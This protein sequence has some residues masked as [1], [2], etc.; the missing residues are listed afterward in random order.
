MKRKLIK[1]TALGLAINMLASTIAPTVAYALTA[2]PS[3]PEFSS[4]E[5]VATTDM[6]SVFSGDFNYNLPV[7]EIPG[8]DGAGYALS[9]AYHAGNSSEEEAS[10]VGYGFTLNPGS[11]NRSTRGFPDDYHNTAIEKYNKSPLNLTASGGANLGL[12]VF[13]T[14]LGLSASKTLRYNN[15]QGVANTFGFGFRIKGIG[16]LNVSTGPQGTT[17]SAGVDIMGIVRKHMGPSKESNSNSFKDVF[18]KMLTKSIQR[19]DVN[20][21]V[22]G[23]FVPS[24][25]VRTTAMS[26]FETKSF[27]FTAS[28]SVNP[29]PVPVGIDAGISGNV[30]V[31]RNEEKASYNAYGYQHNQPS[32]HFSGDNKPTLSDYYIEK[33]SPYKKRE[34]FTG[35]PFNN[36]DNFVAA[37]EGISGGFRYF[38]E[39]AGHFYPD[40]KRNATTLGSFGLTGEVLTAWGFDVQLGLGENVGQVKNWESQGASKD[41]QF[42]K[43]GTFRFAN[44]MG[45]K[46]SYGTSSISVAKIDAVSVVDGPRSIS[47]LNPDGILPKPTSSSYIGVHTAEDVLT[48][49]KKYNNTISSLIANSN[50]QNK[51]GIVE[52]A[53]T[54][55]DGMNYVYGQPVF[56]KNDVNMQF[57]VDHNAS[58]L[59]DYDYIAYKPQSEPVG[60]GSNTNIIDLSKH[61]TAVGE[62]RKVPYTNNY[63]LT[64]ITTPDYVDVNGNG[65][66]NNDFG[67]WTSMHYYNKYGANAPDTGNKWY[68]WRTPYTGLLY[69]KGQIS[70]TTD[71]VGSVSCGEK[72]VQYLKAVETKTHI[73]FFITNKSTFARFSAFIP[74]DVLASFPDIAQRDAY[75]SKYFE[76]SGVARKDGFDAKALDGTSDPASVRR[77]DSR[78]TNELEYLEKVVLFS[79]T[80]LT[81]PLKT[82]RFAYDYSLVQNLP[83]NVEGRYPSGKTSTQSGKLTLK[84]VWFEYEDVIGAKISPYEF[85]YQYKPVIEIPVEIQARYPHIFGAGNY[86]GGKFSNDAQNPDYSPHL[87]DGWGNIQQYAKERQKYM[88]PWAYQGNEPNPYITGTHP[89]N[90]I[91]NNR[92]VDIG[93][94]SDVTPVTANIVKVDPAAWQLKRI[95]LPSG[96]EILIEYEQK[97]YASVQDKAPMA[98]ASLVD[99]DEKNG[100]DLPIYY[101]NGN[102]LGL[103]TPQDYDETVALM[104]KEFQEKIPT[105]PTERVKFDKKIYFKFLYNLKPNDATVPSLDQCT[106]EYISGYSGIYSIIADAVNER[107]KIT[108]TGEKA[109]DRLGVP[110][111]ASHDFYMTQRRGKLDGSFGCVGNLSLEVEPKAKDFFNGNGFAQVG[112]FVSIIKTMIGANLTSFWKKV[113]IEEVGQKLNK[114]LSYLRIPMIKAKKGGGV[115]VKRLMTFDPGVASEVGDAVVYGQEYIY[116]DISKDAS[117]NP[118]VIS[119]GVATNEPSENRE[120][121]PLINFIPPSSNADWFTRITVGEDK[122]QTEG[123]IG[124]SILPSASIGHSRVIVQNIHKGAS[125]TGFT[126]NEYYTV[127]DY[128]YDRTYAKGEQLDYELGAKGV[129]YSNID[130]NKETSKLN[131][132]AGIFNYELDVAHMAQGFRF[133]VN[134]MHGQM[135]HTASYVGDYKTPTNAGIGGELLNYKVVSEQ[136]QVYYEPGEMVKML[137]PDGTWR[138]DLPGKEM[139]MT[140]EMKAVL[141]NTL[142]VKVNVVVTGTAVP[143]FVSFGFSLSLTYID[144]GISTH[145]TSKVIKYPVILKKT[146][147]MQ[148]GVRA[149][150]ENIAFNATTGAPML[151]KTYDGFDGTGGTSTPNSAHDGAMYALNIPASWHYLG[152]GAKDSDAS[153]NTN[154][155]SASA[156]SI[157][158]YGSNFNPLNPED[159]KLIDRTTNR[160]NPRYYTWNMSKDA[161]SGVARQNI[162]SASAQTFK[163]NWFDASTDNDEIRNK[164]G[165]TNSTFAGAAVLAKLNNIWR[166][167]AGFVYRDDVVSSNATANVDGIKKGGVMKNTFVPF[168]YNSPLTAGSKWILGSEVKKYTPYGNAVEEKNVLGVFSSA[169]FGYGEKMPTL[170]ANNAE[171]GATIFKDYEYLPSYGNVGTGTLTTDLM[172]QFHSGKTSLLLDGIAVYPLLNT[173]EEIPTAKLTDIKGEKGAIIRFWAKSAPDGMKVQV[174]QIMPTFTSGDITL[175]KVATVGE[176]S[177]YKG[178]ITG[179]DLP[180]V[181]TPNRPLSPNEKI[182]IQLVGIA[183]TGITPMYLDDLKIQPKESQTTCYVYD[184]ATLR[185]ITQFDDQHFGMF[186]QYNSEGKLI[187]KQVETEKGLKTIQETQYNSQRKPRD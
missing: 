142:D 55:P 168:T 150:T 186:Y 19:G 107:I 99:Y 56:T 26:N 134:N 185:L 70:S 35:I 144:K 95:K 91:P 23:M 166:P 40:Y 158:S 62:V 129:D 53:V 143:P 96:G 89:G 156:G 1:I 84:K 83:N 101:I 159:V 149:V 79:K 22:Y 52:L 90:T 151:T 7:V 48:Y 12:D 81:K 34:L 77:P 183:N 163:N 66:D 173:N 42:N 124:E 78:G 33:G 164:Y 172:A 187:R 153:L 179:S 32:S 147:A 87:L 136:T 38:P 45:G 146:I 54:N 100:A 140:M 128:P 94:R 3:S 57:D 6:V 44:D 68:R 93:W 92:N 118:K 27:D 76:G 105:S 61:K 11:I 58:S 154:Q 43:N 71:D 46:V 133:I 122:E 126:V 176:W 137:N 63:L 20:G 98:M 174:T 74:A 64:Q 97:D 123:P 18:K 157:T 170:M 116:E 50:N 60:I 8:P 152:M 114:S 24:Q 175:E 49:G 130:D 161:S 73:A 148:D 5:P 88:M 184:T 59:R 111:Q 13:A 72:E 115:R 113:K 86:I 171:Y 82:T 181:L 141:D 182:N 119:S 132:P 109:G 117:G 167:W 9:L 121:N 127:K 120:E 169:S 165:L 145:L 51:K 25:D 80:R 103:S 41:Y 69:N 162:L 37:G 4:F 178:I 67:G 138:W 15:N 108:L 85:L 29:G 102:D 28:V 180:P 65:P 75:K 14:H 36:A 131:I 139:D 39:K 16:N 177:M 47:G 155:L 112:S 2:G 106:S 17:Y 10:W 135:R 104:K 160:V 125:S 30:N 21:A 110:R 31:T